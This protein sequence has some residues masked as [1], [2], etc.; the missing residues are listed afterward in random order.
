ML[1]IAL[2]GDSLLSTS[3]HAGR[4]DSGES[5]LEARKVVLGKLSQSITG[6]VLTTS[7]ISVITPFMSEWK[8]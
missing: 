6:A 7:H 4:Q 2:F 8:Q 3:G 1:G 5:G